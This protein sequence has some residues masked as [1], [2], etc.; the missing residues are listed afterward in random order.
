MTGSPIAAQ[1][2]PAPL[3]CG[4]ATWAWMTSQHVQFALLALAAF[5][6]YWASSFHLESAHRT[7]HFAADTWFY[8]ELAKGDVLGRIA[9]DYH[10]DRIF[11]FHPTTVLIAAAWMEVVHPLAQWVA[12][13]H[14]LKALF[15][16]VGAVG[17]WAA[18][19]AFAAVA[20]RRYAIWLGAAY[21]SS[22]SIWYFSSIEESKIVSATLTGLYIATYLYVRTAWTLRGAALLTTVL[23][24]AC[25]NEIVAAFLIVIP[26]VDTLAQR[27]WSLRDLRWIAGHALAAPVA[28]AILEGLMRGR[29]GAAGYHP[30]GANHLSMFLYY[31]AHNDYSLW[32]LHAF[33]VKWLLFSIAAPTPD[34][35]YLAD[36]N[37]NYGG[38]FEPIAAHYLSSPASASL[39]VLLVVMAVAGVL[40]W[41]RQHALGGLTGVLLALVAY[42]LVRGVFF[43]VFIPYECI[44][45]ST[46]IVLAHILVAGL[47]FTTSRFPAKQAL[48]AGV[49]MLL[50]VTNGAF[51]LGQ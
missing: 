38:D 11:R 18:L 34:A 41:R 8:A 1:A 36:A 45:F 43:L 26:L 44:L 19:W 25:L 6:I 47:L 28:L 46:P 30:E 16:V 7:T 27:G 10:L 35:S 3:R 24:V 39:A 9:G 5:G 14:L 51:I 22:L 37:I 42:A 29:M 2:V 20:P 23:L 31:L 50:F 33:L 13:E 32:S 40:P 21:A 17:V 49:A 48:L 12:P 4:R 15:A